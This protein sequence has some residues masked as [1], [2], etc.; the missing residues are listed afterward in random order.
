MCD[1]ERWWNVVT[2]LLTKRQ[3]GEIIHKALKHKRKQEEEKQMSQW[4]GSNVAVVA[5]TKMKHATVEM[6]S[7]TFLR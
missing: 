4:S 7:L 6:T 2:E 3:E 5:R 1:F